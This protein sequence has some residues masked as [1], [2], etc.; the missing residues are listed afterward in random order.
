MRVDG[1]LIDAQAL[2]AACGEDAEILE[3]LCQALRAHLPHELQ[4]VRHA[5]RAND[6]AEVR[7]GAHRVAGMISAFSTAAGLTASELEDEAAL[8]RPVEVS[9]LFQRLE[10]Q[11]KGV[12]EALGGLSI[13]RL[14]LRVG[15]GL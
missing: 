15:L 13:E 10:A 14:R 6:L 9:D 7:E 4:R 1:A 5:L 2:L 8:G 3:K 11:T 12:M